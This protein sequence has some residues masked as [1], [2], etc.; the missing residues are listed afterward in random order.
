[1]FIWRRRFIGI[2]RLRVIFL[3]LWMILKSVIS[4]GR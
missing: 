4:L 2:R 1:M 3:Y